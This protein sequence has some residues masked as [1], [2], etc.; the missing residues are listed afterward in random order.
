MSSIR[1]LRTFIAVARY[2]SFAAAAERVALTQAAVSMQMQALEADLK[3][4]LFDRSGRIAMLN[5][6]GRAMLPRAE[7]LVALYEE[8]RAIGTEANEIVGSVA[9]GAVVSVMGV[10]AATVVRLKSTYPRLEVRLITARSLELAAQVESGEI[11][12]AIL[13]ESQGKPPASLVW[14]P[15]YAEP[16][17]LLASRKTGRTGAA[18]LLRTHP[19]LRF[20]RVQRTGQLIDRVLR[21]QRLAVN[22]FLELSSLEATVELVRQNAGVAVAP[23]LLH[24]TWKHDPALRVLALPRPAPQ[25]VIGMLERKQ[26]ERRAVV[27]A[28]RQSIQGGARPV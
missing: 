16:L 18:E 1:Y 22:D 19:F 26:H 2:G 10:L 8:M 28:I 15:L 5:S 3:H 17:V 12:A 27:A 4:P 24:N 25:R 11:D 7:Q 23:L 14:T 20:E 6:T 21:K 9:I 13:V